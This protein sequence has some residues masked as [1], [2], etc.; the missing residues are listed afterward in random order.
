MELSNGDRKDKKGHQDRQRGLRAIPVKNVS[1]GHD[2][3][4][5]HSRRAVLLRPASPHTDNLTPRK[6]RPA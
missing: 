5:C 2:S 6:G 1:S 4:T 3:R